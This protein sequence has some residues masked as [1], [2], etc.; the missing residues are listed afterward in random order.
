M[1]IVYE[2]NK[3]CQG[4]FCGIVNKVVEG[5]CFQVTKNLL[6]LK[7]DTVGWPIWISLKI[8][9][10]PV[11]SISMNGTLLVWIIAMTSVGHF[12]SILLP[13]YYFLHKKN[14]I[15]FFTG[16]SYNSVSSLP[17]DQCKQEHYKLIW[18]SYFQKIS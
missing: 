6:S 17:K 16:G 8:V 5:D 4:I 3:V 11:F 15:I 1:D 9:P 10:L 14:K 2:I 18:P 12:V 7:F 13:Y